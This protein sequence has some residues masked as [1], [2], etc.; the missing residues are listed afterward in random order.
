MFSF[1]Y[2][3]L[4]AVM[5]VALY[6]IKPWKLNVGRKSYILTLKPSICPT[7]EFSGH[8]RLSC[9][10]H[11]TIACNVLVNS[12]NVCMDKAFGR[13]LYLNSMLMPAIEES[14]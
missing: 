3:H 7:G 14:L 11:P 12:V 6:E 5:K 13:E 10:S 2:D 1:N 4:K 8:V 9:G